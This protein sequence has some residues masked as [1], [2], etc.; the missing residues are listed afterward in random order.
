MAA[1]RLEWSKSGSDI[2][3]DAGGATDADG[4]VGA[5]VGDGADVRDGT[6]MWWHYNCGFHSIA[7]TSWNDMKTVN[8]E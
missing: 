8:R 2:Y 1:P 6:D 7:C 3:D 5:D 4:G